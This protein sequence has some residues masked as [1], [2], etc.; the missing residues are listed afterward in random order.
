LPLP[1]KVPAGS[2]ATDAAEP[3][4]VSPAEKTGALHATLMEMPGADACDALLPAAHSDDGVA[5]RLVASADTA[6]PARE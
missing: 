1:L 3:G 5:A 2:G 6:E 4:T